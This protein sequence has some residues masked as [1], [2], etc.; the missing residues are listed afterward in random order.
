MQHNIRPNVPHNPSENVS[1]PTIIQ[2]KGNRKGRYK[3]TPENIAI[4]SY[5]Q[6]TKFKSKL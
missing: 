3:F 5:T 1:A 4:K 2:R 6:F